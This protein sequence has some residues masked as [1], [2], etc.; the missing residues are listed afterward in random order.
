LKKDGADSVY[1]FVVLL[2]RRLDVVSTDEPS[3]PGDGGVCLE[4]GGVC[5]EDDGV[6]FEDDGDR[7]EDDGDRFEGDGDRFEDDGVCFEDDG[8]RFE[9]DRDRFEDDGVRFEDDRD[10][11]EDDGDRFEDDGDRFEDDGDRFEDDGVRFED[12]RDRFED[13]GVCFEDDR[14]RFEDDGVRF[15]DDGVCFEDDGVCFEDDG[16]RFEDDGDRFEDDRDRFE[17]DR[18]RFEDDRDRFEDDGDRFEDDRDRFEDDGVRF[19]DDGVRFEED[20]TVSPLNFS[21]NGITV[22]PGRYGMLSARQPVRNTSVENGPCCPVPVARAMNAG[23]EMVPGPG[24]PLGAAGQR[25]GPSTSEEAAKES[26]EAGPVGGMVS[27]TSV[28][29]PVVACEGM[30]GPGSSGSRWAMTKSV[31]SSVWSAPPGPC[32]ASA[33]SCVVVKLMP[34][35]DCVITET[36][37]FVPGWSTFLWQ[38]TRS[39]GGQRVPP[40]ASAHWAWNVPPSTRPLTTMP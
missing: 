31:G 15:E 25:S 26:C 24:G 20:G 6:R 28:I 18:D 30:G 29:Q 33:K 17:D 1:A 27:V 9:D 19:E 8:V 12:D 2:P 39:A 34:M 32:G 21:T 38:V 36:F 40:S 14:D 37:A 16:D 3:L 10:R 7:L 35:K 22:A 5:F 23:G 11:F 13:D 4:D